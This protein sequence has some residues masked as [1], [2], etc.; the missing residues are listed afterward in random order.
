MPQG[1]TSKNDASG[2]LGREVAEVKGRGYFGSHAE[3]VRRIWAEGLPMS[4]TQERETEERGVN[5]SD[6]SHV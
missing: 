5:T 4:A 6:R 3:D 2:F 1:W